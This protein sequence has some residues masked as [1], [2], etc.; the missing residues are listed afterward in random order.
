M[1]KTYLTNEELLT[2]NLQSERVHSNEKDEELM[3]LKLQLIETQKMV[4]NNSINDI[5]IKR[6][7]LK[8]DGLDKLNKIHDDHELSEGLKWTYNPET[9]EITIKEH[10]NL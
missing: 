7:N 3:N 8:K 1:E 10:E 6:N 2:L 4:L 5:K 9:G